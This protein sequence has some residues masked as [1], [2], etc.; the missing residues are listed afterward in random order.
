MTQHTSRILLDIR[1]EREV[2]D[3]RWGA[4][5][6]MLPERWLAILAE[7]VGEAAKDVIEG[8][9][10]GKLRA[11]LIQVAAV[12]VAWAEAIDGGQT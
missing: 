9:T 1:D 12:A 5:R 10:H 2:Q 8:A 3:K 7:E 11:E 4:Y 6:K